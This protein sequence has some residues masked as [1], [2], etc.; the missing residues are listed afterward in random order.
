M[1]EGLKIVSGDAEC[2]HDVTAPFSF[3]AS[4]FL[5]NAVTC[6]LTD[7]G[8]F[9]DWVGD[10]SIFTMWK[11]LLQFDIFVTFNGIDFDYPLWGGSIL[12]AEHI[13]ARKFFEKSFKGKTIDLC[14]DFHEALGV[15]A[16]LASVSVPT[17]GD[18]KELDGGFAPQHWR[19]GRCM[20][21]IEYCRGDVRRTLGLLQKC[22]AGEKLKYHDKKNDRIIEFTCIPKLR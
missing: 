17:L 12:G 19:A 22:M 21:V 7:Q 11:Y 18:V 2:L 6:T 3:G 13:E 9:K 16:S 20:E 1:F 4:Q 14:K 15:R 8:E 5:G 10:G